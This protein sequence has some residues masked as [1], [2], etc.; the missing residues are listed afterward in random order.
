[1]VRLYVRIHNVDQYQFYNYM[2]LKP[3]P[4]PGD[5]LESLHN[6]SPHRGS[7]QGAAAL[8]EIREPL[9]SRVVRRWVVGLYG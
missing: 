5:A 4:L 6:G 3:A 1:M 2:S 7:Q 8:Q 9:Y